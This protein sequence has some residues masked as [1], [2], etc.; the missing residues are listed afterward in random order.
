MNYAYT[1]PE[2]GKDFADK[3]GPLRCPHCG[4]AHE[5][6]ACGHPGKVAGAPNIIADSMPRRMHWGLGRE[7]DSRSEKRRL[8]EEKG[9]TEIGA[10]EARDKGHQETASMGKGYFYAGQAARKSTAERGAVMTSD[11]RRVI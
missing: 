11:G 2:F 6:V 7:I 3:A 9:L 4:Q 1:C 10:K 5:A 8:L